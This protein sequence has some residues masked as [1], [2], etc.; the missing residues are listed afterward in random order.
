MASWIESVSGRRTVLVDVP[1]HHRP[2][3]LRY[4]FARKSGLYSLF[5][6]HD[7]GPGAPKGLLGYRGDG[8][9]QENL[10]TKKPKGFEK[11]DEDN[12]K[13]LPRGLQ[14]N[15]AL[16]AA[17]KERLNKVMKIIERRRRRDSFR[18]VDEDKSYTVGKKLSPGEERRQRERLLRSEMRREVP[19]LS[20][21]LTQLK[22]KKSLPAIFFIFSRA[23]CDEAA[24]SAFQTMKG[25]RDPIRLLDIEFEQFDAGPGNRSQKKRKKRP[26]YKKGLVKDGEGRIFRSES[27]LDDS[28]ALSSYFDDSSVSLG[29]DLFEESTPL[30]PENWQYYSKAGLLDMEEVQEVASRITLFNDRNPETAFDGEMAEQF[31]FGIGSH[32]AGL[33]PAHKSFVEV[34]FR[35]QLT[36][37]VFATETLAAGINM[38]ARTTGKR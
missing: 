29:E 14:V 13:G 10:K 1:D 27:R 18:S 22:R 21:V 11:G 6:D 31:L 23:G 32:H 16:R 3:P 33:L 34:L 19:S 20:S 15:P 4:F 24:R 26:Q 37:V 9:P 36:K 7:A 28:N 30:A 8:V 38:P 12:L 5:R 25:P 17:A 2:V 35:R